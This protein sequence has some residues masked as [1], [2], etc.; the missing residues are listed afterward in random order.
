MTKPRSGTKLRY[1]L[2]FSESGPGDTHRY[3]C[4]PPEDVGFGREGEL[5]DA[6]RRIQMWYDAQLTVFQL[7]PAAGITSA[8]LNEI[9]RPVKLAPRG[10]LPDFDLRRI[11]LYE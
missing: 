6:L 9:D 11:N 1:G 7:T 8:Q 10:T 5:S 4:N 2:E 3:P